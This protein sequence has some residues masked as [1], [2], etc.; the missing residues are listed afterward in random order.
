MDEDEGGGFF[1]EEESMI[2]D[3][4]WIAIAFGALIF[5]HEFGHFLIA[6]LSG[7]KVLKFSVG[8]GPRIL[9]IKA[10]ET[11]YLLSAFPL[12]GYVKLLGESPDEEIPEDERDRSFN[13]QS[14]G[15]KM[16]IVAAGPFF[17]LIFAV[18]LFFIANITGIPILGTTVGAIKEGMPAQDS[19]IKVGDRIIRVNG[20]DV[21]RFD[22]LSH[23]IRQS[24]GNELEIVVEREG[25]E[26]AFMIKP[27]LIKEKNIFGEEIEIYVIGIVPSSDYVIVRHGP[28]KAIGYAF[29]QTVN[30]SILTVKT[31]IKLI[32]RVIPA[33]TIGGP[34]L[35]AQMV[36]E[37]AREG[38]IHFVLLMGLLSVNLGILN[39]FPIPVLDGGHLI[40]F[41]IEGFLG[42]QLSVKVKE[43]AQQIGLFIILLI[44]AFAFYN[45]LTRNIH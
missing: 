1:E 39:L 29:L 33:K 38:W 42:R 23:I 32:E 40:F 22:E 11:E 24:G 35:I 13:F 6:K 36:K 27:R 18:F 26:I 21:T 25:K 30:L 17:N 45:D 31:A 7:V 34:I 8:F 14:I 9:G 3:I 28:V 2:Y 5:I 20:K 10:G 15:K 37:R 19:G 43:R 12:G 16:A 41:I 4:I 44:L